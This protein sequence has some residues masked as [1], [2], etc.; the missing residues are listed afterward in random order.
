VFWKRGIRVSG[1]NWG[2]WGWLSWPNLRCTSVSDGLLSRKRFIV[3]LG[4]CEGVDSRG[5]KNPRLAVSIADTTSKL[6]QLLPSCSVDE[7]TDPSSESDLLRLTT[8][9]NQISN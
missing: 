3:R 9:L 2:E 1:C 6:K 4:R 7:K 5:A 8:I